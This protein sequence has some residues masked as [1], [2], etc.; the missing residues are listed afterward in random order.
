[1]TYFQNLS[2]ATQD[3]YGQ[4][5]LHLS[6]LRGHTSVVRYIVQ[7][8][9]RTL[10]SERDVLFVKDKNERTPLDL[11]IHKN[12][13]TVEVVLKEVMANAEDPRGHFFRK[14]LWNGL[15][16]LCSIRSWKKWMGLVP[17][18]MDEMDTPTKMPFY[19]VLVIFALHFLL[20]VCVFAPFGNA[21]VA[22]LWDKSGLLLV[23][24]VAMF[25]TWYFYAKTVRTSP[26]YV[27]ESM[28]NFGKWRQLY[29]ATIESLAD[30][31]SYVGEQKIPKERPFQLLH[32]CHIARPHRSKY[33]R[34]T[35]KCVLL[36][37][38][39]CPFVN[40]TIGLNNYKYFYLFL[41]S[42]TFAILS[43]TVTLVI[44]VFRYSTQH[45]SF[46]WFTIAAGGLI[47][48]I[49]FPVGGLFIYH[50]QLT[51]MNLT[52]NE[53]INLRKYKYLHPVIGGR[54]VFKN[55]WDRGYLNNFMDR[56]HPS[57]A[58]YEIH[59]DFEALI[60]KTAP[61]PQASACCSHH[62]HV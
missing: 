14:T 49:L 48:F 39:F 24:F 38:H 36:F 11:A 62:D 27:D 37:D 41:V 20:M 23:N 46:P 53:H 51:M 50:T 5:P 15:R 54:R 47:S 4:T 13:P 19:F 56:F 59:S 52:T 16:E 60:N 31:T 40:N 45:G 7:N 17:R 34:V 29:E 25:L 61:M 44:Y 3:M 12:R 32:M 26:G 22:L 43:F 21:G 58:S 6:A 57:P 42:I 35:R 2:F 8:L 28:P 1:L 33:C 9:D 18:G 30:E 55:P 10:K